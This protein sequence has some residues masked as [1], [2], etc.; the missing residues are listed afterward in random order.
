MLTILPDEAVENLLVTFDSVLDV[1]GAEL[2]PMAAEILRAQAAGCANEA[3]RDRLL[4][5]AGEVAAGGAC[6]RNA[7][8]LTSKEAAVRLSEIDAASW[9]VPPDPEWH[10]QPQEGEEEDIAPVTAEAARPLKSA[11]P[12]A[13]PRP[14]RT[15]KP[16]TEFLTLNTRKAS[17]L[18]VGGF[19]PTLDPAASNFGR[20]PLARP[21]EQWP[22]WQAKPLLFVC[23]LNLAT[24]PAVPPL[25]ADVQ[26][27][28]FFVDPELEHLHQE[29]GSNWL[30][31]VYSSIEGLVPL[32]APAGA[33]RAGKGFECRWEEEARDDHP[34]Y[35][36]PELI[37]PAGARRPRKQLDNIARTK[38]GG[39]ASTI[40][41]APWWGEMDHPGNPRFCLQI[42]SEEKA[43]MVW[44][45][46][47]TIYLARGTTAGSEDQWF[48]D[49]QMF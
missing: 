37:L 32:E 7:E 24:A 17:V 40:Q 15:K 35:D 38:I 5:A 33:P 13:L 47:G 16:A 48:L 2:R 11:S 22:M 8:G 18:E 12:E 9:Q 29:N 45:D 4:R 31:R 19:R 23:Q 30:L 25:L 21:G 44:G 41:A 49:W 27:I 1:S 43:G 6:A 34:N 39:Y 46:G 26:L 42:N 28:T 36:D 10:E 3:R 14:K 20:T